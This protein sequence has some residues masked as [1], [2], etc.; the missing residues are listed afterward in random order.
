MPT[1][2]YSYIDAA[3]E[4]STKTGLIEA[5]DRDEALW[6]LASQGIDP[7]GVGL[8]EVPPQAEPAR[9]AAAR[10]EQA[11]APREPRTDSPQEPPSACQ[12]PPATAQPAAGRPLS[13]AEA[14]TLAG[15]LSAL[16]RSGLPLPGGLRALADELGRGATASVLCQLADCVE[17]GQTLEAA[18]AMIGNRLPGHLR[19]LITAGAASGRLSEVLEAYVD[20]RRDQA[21]LRHRMWLAMAYPLL[22]VGLLV[23]LFLLFGFFIVPIF[24]CIFDDFSCALPPMTKA[25]IALSGS[26]ALYVIVPLVA[27]VAFMLFV[28][29]GPAP[30]WMK[31]CAYEIPVFGPFW[32][33]SRLMPLARLLTMLVELDT[34]LPDALRL[35]AAGVADQRLAIGCLDAADAVEGGRPLGDSLVAAGVF[36]SGMIPLLDWGGRFGSLSTALRFV[37]ESFERRTRLQVEMTQIAALPTVLVVVLLAGLG[38]ASM[39]LPLIG[40]IE[41]LSK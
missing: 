3:A 27:I 8:V 41:H 18:L 12:P 11:A 6:Q 29:L 16:A 9:E 39:L 13:G 4:P 17:S 15:E 38:V 35:T 28:V 40:L 31:L 36:P 19:G 1:F 25:A 5:A 20:L 26:G 21:E 22:L 14:E 24:A 33:W 32:R 37:D 30:Y 2:R 7:A 10:A 23:A 34:P